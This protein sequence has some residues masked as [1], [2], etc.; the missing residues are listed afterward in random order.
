[1]E[2]AIS[3]Q[4]YQLYENNPKIQAFAVA[5]E[6]VIVWQTEN[7]NLLEDIKSII[8]APETAAGKVSA[9]G[10][11]Y[12]RAKSAQDYYIGT[13]GSDEGHL[14]IV[15]INDSSWAIAWAESSAVPELTIIDLTK[16]AIHL[17]G[18]L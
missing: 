18:N 5:K 14:L 6:G 13:A 1:M 2:S 16:T 9:N 15:K 17:K 7:W 8:R 4:W 11:K 3:R 12:K 10:V